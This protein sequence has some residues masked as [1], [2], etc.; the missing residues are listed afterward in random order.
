MQ[1]RSATGATT[2]ALRASRWSIGTATTTGSVSSVSSSTPGGRAT[3][4][5]RKPQCRRRET[6]ASVISAALLSEST[7]SIRDIARATPA[8]SGREGVR[9][10]GT[11]ESDGQH[12]DAALR[13]PRHQRFHRR[14]V[15]EDAPRFGEEQAARVGERDTL[16]MAAKQLSAE[17]GL[18][19]ADLLAEGRLLDAELRGGAG[20]VSGLGDRDEVAEMAKFHMQNIGIAF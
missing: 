17:R 4:T 7:S 6:T 16:R 19:R 11:R 10:G 3:G 14:H 15:G 13:D 5:R 8:A 9:G 20:H 12:A 2:A 18:E 1:F